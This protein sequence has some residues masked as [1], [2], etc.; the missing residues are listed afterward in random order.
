MIGHLHG[1]T[2]RAEPTC[3]AR[4]LKFEL[5]GSFSRGLQASSCNPNPESPE[6]P[7]EKRADPRVH[8]TDYVITCCPSTRRNLKCFELFSGWG[9][10][11]TEFAGAGYASAVFDRQRD[12]VLQ[13]F[14]GTFL[15]QNL[16][17]CLRLK[18][19]YVQGIGFRV[20]GFKYIR[21]V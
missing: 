10:V 20:Q 3:I 17:E 13:D 4:G 2:N 19:W 21:D 7:S 9:G 8:M 6:D 14:S 15:D 5:Y 11:A 1:Y 12:P 18:P 16:S